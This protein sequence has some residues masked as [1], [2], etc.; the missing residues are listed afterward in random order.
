MIVKN[1]AKIIERLLKSVVGFVDEYCICDTGSTDNTVEVIENFQELEGTV[2][3]APFVNF[4]VSRNVAYE[5]AKKRS[6]ADYI[7]FMDADMVLDISP[8]FNKKKL[9]APAYVLYQESGGL[10]YA[11]LRMVRRSLVGCHYVGVTHEYFNTAGLG[12]SEITSGLKIR[13][14]GDGG[15][16]ADK[17]V[18]DIRLLEDALI[19]EPNNARYRFYLANSYFDL[20][21]F[22]DAIRNY[23]LRVDL[24]GWDE[25]VYYSLYRI[26]LAYRGLDKEDE[27]T[28]YAMKA[29]KFRP[30]RAE[31]I[32]ELMQYY[33]NKQNHKMVVSLYQ[34]V[35]D[36]KL[37]TDKLFVTTHIYTHQVH[38]LYSLSAY[39]AGE[40]SPDCYK[41]L[42]NSPSLN[43]YDQLLNF[44]FYH[45]VPPSVAV[46]FSFTDGEFVSSTPSLV[47][48][49]DGSY[50]MNVR[51]VNYR[52][53]SKTG[54]YINTNDIKTKNKRFY[55]DK[56]LNVLVAGMVQDSV[57]PRSP[58]GWGNRKLHGIEDVRIS[59]QGEN[60]FFTGTCCLASGNIGTCWGKY[61]DLLAPTEFELLGKD[62]EKNWVFLP[63]KLE[64]VYD[65]RPLRF[66]PIEGGKLAL[67]QQREMPLLFSLARGSTNGVEYNGE[68]WFVVHFVYAKANCIRSYYHS[69]VVF[70][71]NMNL[72][73][74]TLPFKFVRH[75]SI[76]YCLGI[77]VEKSRILMSHSV[78]DGETYV[79]IF[80][81]DAFEWINV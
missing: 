67:A 54:A 34:L 81:H 57:Q 4:E 63:G 49:H 22:D 55:L 21:K 48:L 18:R 53:E 8:D 27:F 44:V 43:V 61:S 29:W 15:S 33:Q 25:E 58:T 7:L 51:L 16:K 45:L 41:T 6:T 70:D 71:T 66:G 30:S 2:F 14:V 19:K 56:N 39:Y 13:D 79:R 65:W 9:T 5:E 59:K 62:C 47:A 69:V 40:R 60:V 26:S 3:T 36:V 20:Q 38:Y 24:K 23:L 17:F 52:I 64:M 68:W 76:E 10:K 31:S 46:D 28:M 77:V 73:R 37:S 35:K 80:S 50:L 74:Y 42:L 72:K 11:N 32:G 1:E 78:L 75:N 12:H